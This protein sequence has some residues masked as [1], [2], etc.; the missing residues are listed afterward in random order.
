MF[1][2]G[3]FSRISRVPA[4][5]LRYYDEI[6]LFSPTTVDKFTSYRY[7]S[8][9]QL[10]RLNR[11]LAL[12]H[13]GLSLTE[14][15]RLL[16]EQ[17]NAAELRAMFRLKEAELRQQV[18]EAQERL[19]QVA[20]RLQQIEQEG[21]MPEQD[22]VIKKVDG[23]HVMALRQHASAH[24]IGNVLGECFGALQSQGIDGAAPPLTVYHDP[25][26]KE[27]DMD[28]EIMIPVATSVN[29][30]IELP[31][32]RQIVP[33]DLPAIE[34]AAC[35]VHRG[36]YETLDQTYAVLGQWIEPVSYT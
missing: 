18:T 31:G 27:T 10:P 23:Q 32:G 33:R 16:D 2:I 29:Q 7:Y 21:K 6:G 19:Q 5:T 15:A 28:I 8:A 11:I 24:D 20:N 4:K 13:L 9:D 17:V 22:V 12:K 3:E 34:S 36:S 25:E 30:T 1:K 26:F 35:I 14:I